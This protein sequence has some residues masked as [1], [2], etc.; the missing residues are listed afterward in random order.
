MKQTLHKLLCML[1]VLT[2]LCSLVP[3]VFAEVLE[4]EHVL[5][6][7]V[8]DP[9]HA[10]QHIAT[11]T[12]DNCTY[13]V[14]EDCVKTAHWVTGTGKHALICDKC[15][16]SDT[17]VDCVTAYATLG[18]GFHKQLCT[19][20]GHVY[21]ESEACTDSDNDTDTKCDI[22][23]AE[24]PPAETK[25]IITFDPLTMI[26]KPVGTTQANLELPNSVTGTYRENGEEKPAIFTVIDDWTCTTYDA[27]KPGIYIFTGTVN[28]D[29][30]TLAEGVSATVT[31][32]VK[33]VGEYTL[34][35]NASSSVNVGETM[36]LLASI[37]KNTQGA[38]ASDLKVSWAVDDP[39]KKIASLS[40]EN[41]AVSNNAA[42]NYLRAVSSGSSTSY[43]TVAVTATLKRGDAVL[44]TDTIIVK[45]Y[46]AT[47]TTIKCNVL[48]SGVVF[49]EGAFYSALGY[50]LGR[51]LSYVT[52]GSTGSKGTLYSDSS[53][54]GTKLTDT[55]KCYYGYNSK[56][57]YDGYDL[58][59]VYFEVAEKYTTSPITLT[60]TAYNTDGNV[61][62]TGTIELSLATAQIKYTTDAEGKVTFEEDDF[63]NVL[64]AS[65]KNS[66][67]DYVQFDMSY[68]VFGNAY[69]GSSKYGYLYVDS[70]LKTK[71]TASNDTAK[72]KYNYKSSD[73]RYYYDLDDV[74]YAAGS[75]TGKYTVTIPFTA[76]GTGYTGYE[77]VSGTVV[78]DVNTADT[79]TI[80]YTGTS[81]KAVAKEITDAYKNATYV[82]FS[83]PEEGTL[84]YN[85]DAINS[86]GHKVRSTYAYYLDPVAK[87]EYD[88]DDVYFVP[89]AGQT[90]ATIRFDVY[91][92]KTKLDS[93]SITF[94]FKGRTSSSVFT[95][96]TYANTGSWSAD[97]VD[98][99][100]ANG[101]IKGTGKNQFNPNGSMTRG[102]L[103]LILYRLAGQPS[104]YGVKNPFK[105]VT[106]GDYYY[107]AI[108][109]AYENDV[110][111]GTGRDTFSPKKNVTR[112][113]LAAILYRYTGTPGTSGRLTGFTDAGNV[114]SYAVN[115]MKWA[116]GAGIINGSGSK[117]DPQGSATRAQVAAMLHRYLT[118]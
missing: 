70:T 45:I 88:L 26:E 118:K 31:V 71:L 39:T 99:M 47:A 38:S 6:T 16:A 46:P 43:K 89:A 67:L 104:V 30:Y 59:T 72:F 87:D 44:D 22:C 4:H 50:S 79:F 113:Q 7:P 17:P 68:A 93:T 78:I 64:R 74:T 110:V 23:G 103:V 84:Y 12:L 114:S 108:L 28:T 83:L 115:A 85:Y 19:I 3:A 109:W 101:L 20:C 97:S 82:M 1:L 18:N 111:N 117:L 91:S 80:G 92:G 36:N 9:E 40:S 112:E 24:M 34:T 66:T 95:D 77:V 76:Y 10:G 15:S 32:T 90:K 62:A 41:T 81:F 61:I 57:D 52:F 100:Q 60:Y 11:C 107:K 48:S 63:K 37:T 27:N 86:Y 51:N 8:P 25:T 14:P 75:A 13:S 98:F 105:D 69:G 29:D 5:G 56:T 106:S 33:L 73:S 96:V 49:G 65:Y 2:M 54:Y 102:D 116:V 58:D 94:T 42:V 21:V 35:I 53:R 55:S